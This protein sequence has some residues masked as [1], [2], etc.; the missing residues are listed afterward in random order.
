MKKNENEII[1][2]YGTKA[3]KRFSTL[4]KAMG[5]IFIIFGALCAI[6]VLPFGIAVILMGVLL[7]RLAKKYRQFSE[8]RL[9]NEAKRIEAQRQ[10]EIEERR[11]E[12]QQRKEEEERKKKDE[13]EARRKEGERKAYMEKLKKEREEHERKKAKIESDPNEYARYEKMCSD[14]HNEYKELLSEYRDMEVGE[15][16]EKMIYILNECYRKME[17]LGNI[18]GLGVIYDKLNHWDE[19]EKIEKKAKTFVNKY[20]KYHKDIGYDDYMIDVMS[21]DLDFIIDY[22]M[23]K[24]RKLNPDP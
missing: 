18:E 14:I 1:N 20:I 4:Y 17:V 5:I 13:E 3:W 19:K 24:D 6:P 9:E 8:I 22:L 12:E 7:L 2:K 10:K 11:I 21:L 15:D 23:E 16:A